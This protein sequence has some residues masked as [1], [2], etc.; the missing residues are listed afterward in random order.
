[1]HEHEKKSMASGCRVAKNT[2]NAGLPRGRRALGP[3]SVW[4]C[5]LFSLLGA[6]RLLFWG[7]RK[8]GRVPV[9]CLVVFWWQ[10][11]RGSV[12]SRRIWLHFKRERKE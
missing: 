7:G 3:R 6:K 9:A 12:R 10:K 2:G 11:L 5:I 8:A 1:M 4:C